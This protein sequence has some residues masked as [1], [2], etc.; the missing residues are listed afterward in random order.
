MIMTLRGWQ[1]AIK[2]TSEWKCW[3]AIASIACLPHARYLQILEKT[4]AT[5]M[6]TSFQI[7]WKTTSFSSTQKHIQMTKREEKKSILFPSRQ[8]KSRNEPTVCTLCT[9]VHLQIPLS[10]EGIWRLLNGNCVS[11]MCDCECNKGVLS[12][13]CA[14]GLWVSYPLRSSLSSAATLRSSASISSSSCRLKNSCTSLE[15]VHL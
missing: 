8:S 14:C 1:S 11:R 9:N 12:F 4:G 5:V 10:V 15:S 2:L 3:N 6:S 13:C 7:L